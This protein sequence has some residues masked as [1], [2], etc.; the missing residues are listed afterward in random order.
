MRK[1]ILLIGIAVYGQY[2]AQGQ[3]APNPA[4][5]SKLADILPPSPNAASLG[6]Y[7][8]FDFGLNTG[9][10]SLSVPV[11]DY[12]STNIAVPISLSYNSNGVKVDE[13]GS[14]VGISWSLNAGGVITRTVYGR[15]DEDAR[16]V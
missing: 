8:G 12:F 2:N 4:D 9:T 6:K 7:G 10:M 15:N 13:I 11:C 14:R 1:L 5:Y 16:R 3:A